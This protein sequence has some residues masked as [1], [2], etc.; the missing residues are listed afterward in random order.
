[1]AQKPSAAKHIFY[2]LLAFFTLAFAATGIGEI[3]FQVINASFPETTYAYESVYDA[4]TMRFG[5][6]SVIVAAPIYWFMTFVI[7]KEL[8][9]GRMDRDT[10]IRKFLTYFILLVSS[11]TV[12]SSLMALLN[13]F[14]EGELT[15]KFF[16]KVLTVLMLAA[17]VLLYYAYD[18]RRESFKPDS[19]IIAFRITFWVIVAV[20]LVAGFYIHGS[21]VKARAL[22]EDAERINRLQNLQYTIESYF[23]EEKQLPSDLSLLKDRIV[24]NGTLDPVSEK[25]FEYRILSEKSYEI[26]AEFTFSNREIQPQPSYYYDYRDPAWLHDAG[27]SCFERKVELQEPYPEFRPFPKS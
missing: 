24:P 23:Q 2:Y 1:M 7:N 21:P 10:A 19:I 3:L 17:L 14:L 16:L 26:C 18:I 9:V 6:S 12:I 22:R 25:S 13:N 15:I 27:R 20:S 11:I 4:W 8:V 5:L